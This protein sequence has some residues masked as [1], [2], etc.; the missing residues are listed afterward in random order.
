MLNICIFDETAD[1]VGAKAFLLFMGNLNLIESLISDDSLRNVSCKVFGQE[2]VSS[3]AINRLASLFKM[4]F[5]NVEIERIQN[6]FEFIL[7]FWKYSS[8]PMVFEFLKFIIT[9]NSMEQV[10]F[11]LLE[12]DVVNFTFKLLNDT[13][14][15]NEEMVS[16]LMKIVTMLGSSS[17]FMEQ[18]E[19]IPCNILDSYLNTNINTIKNNLWEMIKEITFNFNVGVMEKYIEIAKEILYDSYSKVNLYIVHCLDFLAKI[20]QFESD[21]HFADKQ[22]LQVLIRLII[23]FPNCSFLINE[24][25]YLIKCLID[26]NKT[27]E[28]VLTNMV[29]F[30]CHI[31]T[32]PEITSASSNCH[33]ILNYIT[34]IMQSNTSIQEILSK[35]DLYEEYFK[36][37]YKPYQAKLTSNYGGSIYKYNICR[38]NSDDLF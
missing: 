29:P 5:Q 19:I 9:S 25:F 32:M 34:N 33:K 15:D 11:Y 14:H 27:V 1:D 38:S 17:I 20:A 22:F 31:S 24:I 30:F 10:Q 21:F 35:L 36:Y 2:S 18:F 3:V 16:S 37:D 4:V 13:D 28:S 23:Q 12:N 6:L 7:L 26:N 8:E